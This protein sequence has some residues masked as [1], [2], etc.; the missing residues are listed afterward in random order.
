MTV[1]YCISADIQIDK[2]E[3]RTDPYIHYKMI[4]NKKN[5][6]VIQWTMDIERKKNSIA[7]G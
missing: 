2:G 3:Y 7:K 1:W 4:S 5:A 6:K